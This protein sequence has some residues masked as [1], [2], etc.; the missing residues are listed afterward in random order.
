MRI[1]V[2]QFISMLIQIRIRIQGF[3][4]SGGGGGVSK[5]QKST[6]KLPGYISSLS[7]LRATFVYLDPNQKVHNTRTESIRGGK[8]PYPNQNLH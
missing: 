4:D 7:T 3:D 5:Y 8:V 6:P 1:Q 2:R